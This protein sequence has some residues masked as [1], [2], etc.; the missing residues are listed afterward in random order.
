VTAEPR[1]DHA[2]Y[3]KSWIAVLKADNRVIFT[4][5]SQAGRGLARGICRGAHSFQ[6][7]GGSRPIISSQ[8]VV[9]EGLDLVWKSC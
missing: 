7:R 2:H 6:R 8:Y 5:A 1:E 4:A 9:A 3:L